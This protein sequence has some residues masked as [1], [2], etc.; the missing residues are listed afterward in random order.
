VSDAEASPNCCGKVALSE[1]FFDYENA[2]LRGDP[3][4]PSARTCARHC[5]SVSHIEARSLGTQ[6]AKRGGV[7]TFT[8]ACGA[9]LFFENTRCLS[10]NSRL[11][12]R[13]DTLLLVPVPDPAS[14]TAGHAFRPC[15]NYVENG[16]CN[17]LLPNDSPHRLCAACRL[18]QTIPNLSEP[19]NRALWAEVES[20]KRRLIYGL[21]RLRLEVLSKLDDPVRGLSFDIKSDVGDE[22]VLTGH[23]DGL[24]TLNIEEANPEKRERNR[25]A[26]KE[27]YRTLLG[28]FRHEVG[29]YYWDRLVREG[30]RLDEFRKVFG[31]ERDD[32]AQ[33]L[34]RHYA[35]PL[36]DYRPRYISCYASSHPWE[37]FAETFAHYLHM[38]DTLETAQHFGLAGDTSRRP[39]RDS[40]SLSA[41]L[42]DWLG[43]TVALNAL[44]RSMGL[45]DA[46]PFALTPLVEVKLAFVHELVNVHAVARAVA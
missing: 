26:L 2:S 30:N 1:A 36:E 22:R 37:D 11:G 24:I 20:A 15:A 39:A 6:V 31:D 17:W 3:L 12:F 32:Y 34:E 9:R 29:H 44:N 38:R 41:L 33:A 35:A 16:V 4:A 5:Y 46:Y 45:P 25:L 8:C 13:P 23:S 40:S 27:R 42:D 14:T 43:L 28:H 21:R 18:N 7:R 10:C 19:S